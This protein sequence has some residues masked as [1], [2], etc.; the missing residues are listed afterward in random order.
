M[1]WVDYGISYRV[2][3]NEFGV[4]SG[5]ENGIGCF[6]IKIRMNATNFTDMM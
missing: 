5:G 3:V 1:N 6:E 4:N 2:T